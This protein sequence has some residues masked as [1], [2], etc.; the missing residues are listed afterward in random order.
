ML[1]S[2]MGNTMLASRKKSKK[3]VILASFDW[4]RLF[5]SIKSTPHMW[6]IMLEKPLKNRNLHIKNTLNL[7]IYFDVYTRHNTPKFQ[8]HFYSTKTVIMTW[9]HVNR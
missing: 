8:H 7:I 1:Q 3:T 6:E 5:Y 4:K 9:L 2:D